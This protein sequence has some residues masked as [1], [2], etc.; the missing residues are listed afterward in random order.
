[1]N[2]LNYFTKKYLLFSGSNKYINTRFENVDYIDIY[3]CIFYRNSIFNGKGGSIFCYQ[4]KIKLKLNT[5]VFY[6]CFSS[7]MG[8]A[9]YIYGLQ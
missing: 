3:S 4:K 6:H 1:M 2:I 7:S 5:C 8:G 9:I